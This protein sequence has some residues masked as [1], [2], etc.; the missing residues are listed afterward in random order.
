MKLTLKSVAALKLPSGKTDHIEFDDD[1]SGF[2]LRLREGGSRS[3]IF[4]YSLGSKQRR[5][6]IG[7]A[8]ALT[9][10]KA[11]GIAADLHA[12]VRLGGDPAADKAIGK[13]SAALSFK[14]V[15]E[16][17][18]ARQR[19]NLRPRSYIEVERHILKNGK[20]LHGMPIA[21]IDQRTVAALLGGI[22]D[23]KGTVTANRARASLSA[24]FGWAM[25]EGLVAANPVALTNKHVEQSRDRVLADQE[26][27]LIWKAC[28][29]D[30]FGRIVRILMLTGQRLTEISDLRKSEIDSGKGMIEL[31]GARTK[32]GRPHQVPMSDFVTA[33]L[34]AQTAKTEGRDLMFGRGDVRAFSGWMPAKRRLDARIAE[35]NRKPLPHWVLHDLRR[36]CATRMADLGVQPHVIE[37]VLNHVSG[38]KSGIAGIYNRAI[39]AAEKA[40]ALTLWASHIT[41]IVEGRASNVT[42]LKRA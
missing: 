18:L 13:A 23:T 2:G 33:I 3:W 1:I 14:A 37:A 31:P 26:L 21:A 41:A 7:K 20:P 8:S 28:L 6:A 30:D 19:L 27:G 42:P 17:Y 22:A 11:R 34:A 24:M 5:I 35:A 4:Q 29:E 15:A 16:R 25:R 36:T 40:Q 39:Y 9:P 10:D 38:H 32:N 12:K